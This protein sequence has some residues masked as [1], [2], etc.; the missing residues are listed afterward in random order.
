MDLETESFHENEIVSSAACESSMD[1]QIHNSNMDVD[2]INDLPDDSENESINEID[3]NDIA[4]NDADDISISLENDAVNHNKLFETL[5]SPHILDTICTPVAVSQGE[6]LLMFLKFAVVN[7]LTHTAVVELFKAVNCIFTTNVLPDTGYFIDKLFFSSKFVIYHAICPE[8]QNYAGTFN[9]SCIQKEC[10]FCKEKFSVNG[11]NFTNFYATFD[12]KNNVK[13]CLERNDNYYNHVMQDRIQETDIFSDIYDGR[14][15][16]DFVQSLPPEDKHQYVTFTFNCDGAPVFESSNTSIYPI[17]LM[18]N[19]LPFEVRTKETIVAALWFGK[20]KPNMNVFLKGYVDQMNELTD[21][22]V[23]CVIQ[24][25]ARLIRPFAICCSVDS[26]ARYSMQGV[27]PHNSYYPCNWCLQKGKYIRNKANTGG[28]VKFPIM[29]K[30]PEERNEDNFLNCLEYLINGPSTETVQDVMEEVNEGQEQNQGHE[31]EEEEDVGEKEDEEEEEEEEHA[32]GVRHVT[33][34][35]LLQNFKMIDG[36]VPED[37][38]C[39]RLGV[40]AQFTNIWI[41]KLSRKDLTTIDNL[42]ESFSVPHQTMRLTRSITDRAYWKAKE[43]E[44]WILFYSIPIMQLFLSIKLLTHWAQFVEAFYISQKTSITKTDIERNEELLK[45]FIVDIEPN[46][47]K[48]AMT[49]NVHQLWHRPKSLTNWGPSWAH[50]AFAFEA[51]N[52][53]ILRMINSAN[54]VTHQICRKLSMSQ[55]DSLLSNIILPKS[56]ARVKKYCFNLENKST[57][58]TCKITSSRYFGS[59]KA[60]NINWI[61]KLQLTSKAVSYKKMVKSKCLFSV[62]VEKN[63]HSDNSYAELIDGSFVKIKQFIVDEQLE[64]EFAIVQVFVTEN[65]CQNLYPYLKKMVDFERG[66]RAI[67]TK[68]VKN[69]SVYLEVQQDEY[70]CSVPN[71]FYI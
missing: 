49:F 54:G 7:E 55:S 8:C 5:Q 63:N 13:S 20:S 37:M 60:A 61:N 40:G 50:N 53:K 22:R 15:Y 58:K 2:N 3:D 48:A 21:S 52:G 43:W 69:I 11:K 56:S 38:H 68:N 62:N 59:P 28:C 57:Q 51:G 17:Q 36:F 10:E 42:L 65:A 71:L 24:G 64:K 32:Y 41:R 34:L 26:V 44:N 31:Q 67:P 9:R 46:Y 14:A 27:G 23:E 30:V 19:E 45:R 12:I 47:S 33:P 66:L 25:E 4:V 1:N 39:E 35:N 16:S 6:L 29:K 70:I 18:I